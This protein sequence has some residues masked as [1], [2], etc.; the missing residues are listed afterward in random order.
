MV[1]HPPTSLPEVPASGTDV[2]GESFEA[3]QKDFEQPQETASE[4]KTKKGTTWDPQKVSKHAVFTESSTNFSGRSSRGAPSAT[5]IS[6]QEIAMFIQ[7]YPDY[8]DW[9]LD[10]PRI[11]TYHDNPLSE[12]T[13]A[14]AS[15]SFFDLYRQVLATE[16]HKHQ[17]VARTEAAEDRDQEWG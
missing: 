8:P 16:V 14:T 11:M 15:R 12:E 17:T 5:S 9:L 1:Y 2:A 3:S 7:I 6:A 13:A 10:F 4:V